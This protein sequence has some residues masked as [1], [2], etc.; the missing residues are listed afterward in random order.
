MDYLLFFSDIPSPTDSRYLQILDTDLLN[1]FVDSA[2]IS[3]TVANPPAENRKSKQ[4]L[5]LQTG[6]QHLEDLQEQLTNFG[7][8]L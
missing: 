6:L 8:T 4:H 5:L 1:Q 2:S 7:F 3:G